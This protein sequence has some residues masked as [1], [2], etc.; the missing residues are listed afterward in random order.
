METL[1]ITVNVKC[2]LTQI[3]EQDSEHGR[4]DSVTLYFGDF[5]Y[6]VTHGTV[7]LYKTICN[8]C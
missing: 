5:A 6:T 7:I 4:Q 3:C 2:T 1:Q 8:E